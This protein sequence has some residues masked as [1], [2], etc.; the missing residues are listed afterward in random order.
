MRSLHTQRSA[1]SA[2]RHRSAGVSRVVPCR[3]RQASTTTTNLPRP[4][5]CQGVKLDA[6]FQALLEGAMARSS[7]TVGDR[8]GIIGLKFVEE[9]RREG[10]PVMES[11]IRLG[12]YLRDYK[13]AAIRGRTFLEL[14]TGIGVA[15]LTAAA[16]GATVLLT[17]L[18]EVVPVAGK[19]LAK[20]AD[21]IR[22]AGGLAQVAALDWAAPS[23]ELLTAPWDY[24]I[25]SDLV[26]DD[27]SPDV[28]APLLARLLA[29]NPRATVLLA[30]VHRSSQLDDHMTDVFGAHGLSIRLAPRDGEDTHEEDISIIAVSRA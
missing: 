13:H 4:I 16:F 19:N 23:E 25:G 7:C 22:G 5:S 12:C 15:G 14:G 2:T 24:I 17:D 9:G 18:P 3:L 1:G 27:R 26:Y 28:L 29:S 10:C 11:A 21:L 8:V 6:E 30:H 20:N